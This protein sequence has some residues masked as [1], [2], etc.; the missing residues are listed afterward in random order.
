VSKS[1]QISG[2]VLPTMETVTKDSWLVRKRNT[3][4]EKYAE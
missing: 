4:E 2:C 3:M 1:D